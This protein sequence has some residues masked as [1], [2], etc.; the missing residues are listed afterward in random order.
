MYILPSY[1]FTFFFHMFWRILLTKFLIFW[2]TFPRKFGSFIWQLSLCVLRFWL[3]QWSCIV[4]FYK[5]YYYRF[6]SKCLSICGNAGAKAKVCFWYRLF[7]VND[8]YSRLFLTLWA[9]LLVAHTASLLCCCHSYT[10]DVIKSTL[11]VCLGCEATKHR[12]T[13]SSG[14][15][16]SS[17]L[18]RSWRV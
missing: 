6:F 12:S 8:F 3:L 15:Q 5:F 17:R 4:W 16:T 13:R 1:N 14:M 11:F 9:R 10:F 18:Y 2:F 7:L